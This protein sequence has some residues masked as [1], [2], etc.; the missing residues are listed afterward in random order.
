MTAALAVALGSHIWIG[1]RADFLPCTL[2]C[3]ETYEAYVGAR[4]LSRFGWWYNGGLQDYSASPD[5]MTHP[6]NYVHNPN[7]GM[8]YFWL[9]FTLGVSGVHALAAW[10]TLPFLAGLLYLYMAVHAVTHDGV[11]AGLCLLSAATLYLLVEVWGFNGVRVWSWLVTWGTTY[12]LV[13]AWRP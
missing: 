12:H 8:H 9:L 7:L 3:G 5:L 2:D 13:R 4:N 10:L 11:L 6:T 1:V